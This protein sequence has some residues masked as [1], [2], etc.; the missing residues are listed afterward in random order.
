MDSE[1]QQALKQFFSAQKALNELGVITSRDYIGDVGRHLCREVYGLSLPKGRLPKG[2]RP[3]SHDGKIGRLRV[4]V[5][6]NNC[7]TGTPVRVMEPLDF[8]ELVVVLGP[9]CFLR[10][11][12]VAS[13][14]IFYRLK[15][16]EVRERFKTTKGGYVGG[17]EAFDR[18]YDRVLNLQAG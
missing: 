18:T 17:R 1:T 2:R 3:A 9:N 8:D 16:D 12:G 7:P 5:R 15:P 13:D 11:P 10:P 14:F 4:A 6:M